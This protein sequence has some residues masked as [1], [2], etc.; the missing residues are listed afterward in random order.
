[1]SMSG[2]EVSWVAKVLYG[3]QTQVKNCQTIPKA[4]YFNKKANLT[5]KLQK[6]I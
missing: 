5:T 2:Q 3:I 1:M 6:T 4:S